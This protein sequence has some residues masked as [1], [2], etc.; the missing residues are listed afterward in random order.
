MVGKGEVWFWGTTS[1]WLSPEAVERFLLSD[2]VLDLAVNTLW[3]LH[4]SH[5]L[6]VSKTR[7]LT[8]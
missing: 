2:Q 1:V 4:K 3:S 5:I 8:L 6:Q 7:G